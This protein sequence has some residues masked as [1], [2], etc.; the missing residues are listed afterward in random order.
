MTTTTSTSFLETAAANRQR[1]QLA[2]DEIRQGYRHFHAADVVLADLAD[3]LSL[4]APN[5]NPEDEQCQ[6]LN[7][8][9][10]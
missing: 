8:Q 9:I 6:D 3:S 1:I 7:H 5:R 4:L 10:G 2:R